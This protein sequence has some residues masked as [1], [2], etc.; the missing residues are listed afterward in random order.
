M[1][2]KVRQLFCRGLVSFFLQLQLFSV[3]GRGGGLVVSRFSV[4]AAITN[5]Y[6][7]FVENLVASVIFRKM[8]ANKVQKLSLP[9]FV[10]MLML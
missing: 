3:G 2:L 5:F 6:V 7:A 4:C 9:M 10:F 8:S 1:V